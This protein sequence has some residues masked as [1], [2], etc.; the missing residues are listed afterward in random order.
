MC[1][2][3]LNRKTA[4]NVNVKADTEVKTKQNGNK[5][6]LKHAWNPFS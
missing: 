1:K 2:K 5:N 4:I 3:K 6:I